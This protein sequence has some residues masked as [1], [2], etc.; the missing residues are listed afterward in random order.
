MGFV[1]ELMAL[2]RRKTHFHVLR[3]P[4]CKAARICH[5]ITVRKGDVTNTGAIPFRTYQAGKY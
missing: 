4:P 5:T 3:L 1:P 2:K